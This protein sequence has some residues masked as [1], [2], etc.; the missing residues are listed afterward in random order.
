MSLLLGGDGTAHAA[1]VVV[2][3]GQGEIQGSGMDFGHGFEH[4]PG[5]GGRN[6]EPAEKM[7]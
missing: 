4:L 6:A 3:V 5:E 2:D 7:R 1:A